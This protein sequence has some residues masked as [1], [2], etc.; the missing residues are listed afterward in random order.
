MRHANGKTMT[1][2]IKQIASKFSLRVTTCALRA[3]LID[4]SANLRTTSTTYYKISW[5]I[6][7]TIHKEPARMHEL[8]KM[9]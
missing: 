4:I 2:R 1:N 3:T 9:K 5:L 8:E 7:R 6:N